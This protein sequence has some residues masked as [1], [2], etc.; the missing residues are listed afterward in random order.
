MSL[1]SFYD[2]FLG[3]V[4]ESEPR[5]LADF[6]EDRA[7]VENAIV[8]RNTVFRGA[9]DALATAFPAVARLAGAAYFESVAVAYVGAEPPRQRS[10]VG[11]GESFPAF[12]ERAPGVDQAPYLPDAA[13]LDQAWL[14]AHRAAG[15]A[16]LEAASLNAVV[17]EKLPELR[18]RLHPSVQLTALAWSLHDAWKDNRGEA[19]AP[20][21]RDVRHEPQYVTHWR[22]GYEVE[23]Q[24]LSPAEAR[25]FNAL[26]QDQA[27]GEAAERAMACASNFNISRVFAGALEAGV[28]DAAQPHLTTMG[29][30]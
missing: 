4:V 7:A 11:Y 18:L 1:A 29:E 24:V 6:L 19:A 9:A 14:R 2:A 10:L 13:R 25:F 26:R 21:T 17:P 16:A 3:A 30:E 8:Y 23:S 12:L 20:S 5:G 15:G 27:L 28:F 22:L